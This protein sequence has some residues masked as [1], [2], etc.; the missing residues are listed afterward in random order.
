MWQ[1]ALGSL[2]T[3][4]YHILY[5]PLVPVLRLVIQ[6]LRVLSPRCACEDAVR[7]IL[8]SRHLPRQVSSLFFFGLRTLFSPLSGYRHRMPSRESEFSSTFG[9]CRATNAA[10]WLVSGPALDHLVSPPTDGC[11]I[12]TPLSPSHHNLYRSSIKATVCQLAASN[13]L[14]A[15][16]PPATSIIQTIIN[17]RTRTPSLSTLRIL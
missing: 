3:V 1:M 4:K 13:C 16:H 2:G 17:E 12:S 8:W 15:R 5:G 9:W 6:G 11:H 14:N 10:S 7:I